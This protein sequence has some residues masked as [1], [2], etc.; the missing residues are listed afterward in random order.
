MISTADKETLIGKWKPTGLLNGSRT[1]G[2]KDL[3]YELCCLLDDAA[4]QKTC[5]EVITPEENVETTE[6]IFQIIVFLFNQKFPIKIDLLFR[7]LY[8]TKQKLQEL[9]IKNAG[10]LLMDSKIEYMEFFKNYYIKK[11]I[12]KK[13]INGLYN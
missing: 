6:L 7:E 4:L 3:Q 11:H 1:L 10:K 12:V 13:R 2:N 5:I 8:Q 9:R